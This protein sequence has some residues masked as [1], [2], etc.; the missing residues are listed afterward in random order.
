MKIKEEISKEIKE[1]IEKF[2]NQDNELNEGINKKEI[3]KEEK[4]EKFNEKWDEDIF[5]ADIPIRD[6]EAAELEEEAN[7]IKEERKMS[8]IF[9]YMNWRD[10]NIKNVEFNGSVNIAVSR[11]G[12]KALDLL[13]RYN[14]VQA[15]LHKIEKGS[16]HN[17]NWNWFDGLK[18]FWVRDLNNKKIFKLFG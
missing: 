15:G 5:P 2:N 1:Y 9:D 14:L 17:M 13:N 11:T 7:K 10:I 6:K 12:L 8:N 4:K 3:K 16:K 18:D